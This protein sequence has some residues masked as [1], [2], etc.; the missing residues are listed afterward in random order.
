[1]T[2]LY[3]SVFNTLKAII[4]SRFWH[5][6]LENHGARFNKTVCLAVI[7]NAT[8]LS[9]TIVISYR[10]NFLEG[11]LR[12]RLVMSLKSPSKSN[13]LEVQEIHT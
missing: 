12:L 10:S 8:S 1:M 6:I 4:F 5:W 11:G 2:R 7:A 9:E 13:F 3:T